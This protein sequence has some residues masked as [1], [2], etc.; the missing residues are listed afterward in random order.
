M[1]SSDK[2]LAVISDNKK[3][4]YRFGVNKIGLFGS[5]VRS[6]ETSSSDVD[7]LVEFA[8]GQKSFD[9]YMGLKF[10][11]EEI[12]ECK[13]DLVTIEG[14]KPELAPNILGSV[15]YAEYQGLS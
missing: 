13:V 9:N 12:F 2:I 5:Y 15:K 7:I 4:M 8:E 11:L 10:F 14:V 1:L 6:E 3:A